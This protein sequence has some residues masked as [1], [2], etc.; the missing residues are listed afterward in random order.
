MTENRYLYYLPNT[1]RELQE[2][3]KLAE[4]EG[5]ILKEEAAAKEELI[6]NQWILTAERSGLLRLSG[7]MGLYGAEGMETEKLRAE[8]LSGW[9]S[10]SPYTLFHL[11][12]WLDGCLGADAYRIKAEQERYLLQVVL[13]LRV[14]DRKEFLKKHLRKI[15][16]AN[17]IL[18]VQLNTNMHE[19]LK[20]MTHGKMK[21]LG[22]KQ[23]QIALEDLSVFE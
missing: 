1:V 15:I 18:D 21:T 9:S 5:G 14:K 17:L 13:E 22:W 23:G 4:M 6:R 7:I 3:Q 10:R 11:E 19:D 12:D 8:I 16:P 20:G 2:F